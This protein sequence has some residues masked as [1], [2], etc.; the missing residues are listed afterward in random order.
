MLGFKLRENNSTK[1]ILSTLFLGW[2]LEKI[3][4]VVEEIK[5]YFNILISLINVKIN[6]TF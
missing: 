3:D 6:I 4:L 2:A 1:S 5:R